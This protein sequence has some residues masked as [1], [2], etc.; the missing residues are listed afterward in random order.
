M[1]KPLILNFDQSVHDIPNTNTVDLSLWQDDIRFGCSFAMFQK[2]Q[3][4]L[5]E[6]IL[7]DPYATVFFGSGD[8]HHLSALLVN[9]IAQKFTQPFEVVVLD[10]HPD[11]MRFPF[12]IHCGSWVSHIAKLPYVS[13]VHVVGIT[14]ADISFSHLWENRLK[15]L[16]QGKLTYWSI[17]IETK[18]MAKVGLE[19]AFRNFNHPNDLIG[20]FIEQQSRSPKPTYLSIDKD[21]LS[22]DTVQTNWDQG[23]L[24]E[25]HLVDAILMLQPNIIG[26]DITGEVSIWHYKDKWKRFLSGLDQQKTI[27]KAEVEKWQE[28]QNQLNNRLLTIL[29]N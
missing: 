16:Y 28:A 14:S 26:S 21:V 3:T 9:R 17:G 5:D 27:S 23:C 15:P 25:Q 8:Y 7:N 13:H 24:L 19:H 6:L 11:N 20:A 18:W 12:G 22:V 10:N 1:K 2:L 29:P 4:K